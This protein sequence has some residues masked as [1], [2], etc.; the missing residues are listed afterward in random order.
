[1][2]K[3]I[4]RNAY[5]RAASLEMADDDTRQIEF[6]IS[7][8]AVDSYDT[9]FKMDGWDLT[10]Y[11]KNPIVCY[12]HRSNTD[13]PDDI[14]GT[15]QVFVDGDQLIGRVTFEAGE[16]N[17]KAEKVYQK[18]LAGTLKMASVGAQIID[19]RMGDEKRGEDKNILYF[20]QQRLMEWSIVSAGANP[21]ALKRNEQA[22]DEIRTEA[23]KEITII[24]KPVITTDKKE[25]RSVIE[26]QLII[27]KN[28]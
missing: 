9:V 21:D 3:L 11:A 18:V 14:I 17:P 23:A 20:T 5:V 2:N 12:Q 10:R 19:G 25:K 15:S 8:E 1:M 22:I 27:N 6:V 28:L 26:A 16:I 7:S 13:N 24:D 4:T